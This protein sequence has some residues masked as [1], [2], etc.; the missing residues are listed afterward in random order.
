MWAQAGFEL[1][2]SGYRSAALSVKRSSPQR[3]EASFYPTYVQEIFLR[4]PNAYP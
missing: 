4:Q 1:A 2:P 3:M